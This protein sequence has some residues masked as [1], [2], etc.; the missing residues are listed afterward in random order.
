[1]RGIHFAEVD[2]IEIEGD[3]SSVILDGEI[4]RTEKG[5]PIRLNPA[6]PLSFVKLAA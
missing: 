6:E 1:M 3:S 5:R 4:F 2:E